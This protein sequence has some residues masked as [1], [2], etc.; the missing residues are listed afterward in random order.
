MLGA[1]T[2][3]HREMQK[4][5]HA[6]SELAVEAAKP[7]W[8]WPAPAQNTEL[9]AALKSALGNTLADAFQIRDKLQRRDAINALKKDVFESLDGSGRSQGLVACR[10]FQ[11]I[12]RSR[13][14]HAARWR[15]E[16]QAA[17]RW[18]QSRR[19]PSDHGARRRVAAHA[20]LGAVH[21]R[22][23]AGAGRRHAR[24]HARCA[25]RRC[26]GRRI[27]GSVPVPL[28]LPAVLGRRNRPHGAAR[29]AAKSAMAASPSA[30][31]RP[32]SRRW[33]RSRMCCASS[34]RSPSRTVHLRWPRCAVPRWR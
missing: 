5:I 25:D 21:A 2:F 17:H 3:G 24:H 13:I 12:R 31:C 14:P 28:Q 6:I 33:N 11:G 19:H 15:S 26:A 7:S 1:V 30:A 34:P 9:V 18:P 29:S 20:R 22:R 8:N 23:D 4:V 16:D 10:S 27:E 32:S